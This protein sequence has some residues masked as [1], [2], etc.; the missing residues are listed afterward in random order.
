[1]RAVGLAA[2]L[3]SGLN[4]ACSSLPQ[5][6]E[7][8][9]SQSPLTDDQA[10]SIYVDKGVNYMESGLYEVALQDLQKAIELNDENSE[11]HN[12]IAV[13]YQRIDDRSQADSHFRK[14]LS[15]KPDNFGA[16]N[17]YGRFLCLNE[18]PQ[19]AYEQFNLVIDTKLYGQPWIPLT[20][21]GVCAHSIGQLPQAENY[22]RK[23]LVANPNFPPAL[24]EM[25]KVSRESGQVMAAR[26][27]LQRYLGNNGPTPEALML[28]IEIEM[29]LGNTQAAADYMQTL[30]NQFPDA[31][32]VMQARQKLRQ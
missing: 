2:L 22:L 21:A 24:L 6:E 5:E 19:D 9:R 10:S 32:E 20:N 31:T 4:A 16:S 26:G 28:G 17:N 7:R 29:G 15:L 14:A 13:L 27:F 11:A 25:A 3:L 18:R 8:P 23:A 30:R 1:M 12:A